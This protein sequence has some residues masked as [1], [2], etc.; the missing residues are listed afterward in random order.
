MIEKILASDIFF[1]IIY[2]MIAKLLAA[3]STMVWILDTR[4][5]SGDR[6]KFP[7]KVDYKHYNC[8]KKINLIEDLKGKD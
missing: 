7:D 5:V 8:A 2:I 1:N 6:A 4:H 3:V